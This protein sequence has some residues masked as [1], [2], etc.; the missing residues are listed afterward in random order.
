MGFWDGLK[1][2]LNAE[3]GRYQAA[4]KAVR[5]AHCEG[6][7]FDAGRAQLNTAVASAMKL[8]WANPTA[9]TLACENCGLIAWFTKAPERLKD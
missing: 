4:G 6:E 9:H 8:D 3:T 2:G 1:R 5:C 7:T